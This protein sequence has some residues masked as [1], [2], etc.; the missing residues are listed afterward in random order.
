M[1]ISTSVFAA[2]TLALSSTVW[3]QD[4][5]TVGSN[6]PG[7]DI[8]EWVKGSETSIENGKV[9]VVEFWATWCGPCKQSIPHLTSLQKE[10]ADEGLTIIGISTDTETEKVAPFVRAQ[11]GKMDYTVAVDRRGGTARAWMEAAGKQGIPCAFIVDRQGKVAFIG[12]PHPQANEGF[13][14]ALK[15]VMSGRFDPALQKS[16]EPGMKAART[17][18]KENNWRMAL[19]HYDEV[20]AVDGRIF[21]PLAGEKFEMML[22]DMKDKAGAY[23]YATDT[24]IAKT[25]ANDAEALRMMADKIATDPKIDPAD[26]DLDV[27]LAAA[28]ASLKV[29]GPNNAQ[30]LATLAMVRFSRGEVAQAIDL[31]KQA[32]MQASSK[33]KADYRRTLNT[34]QEASQRTSMITPKK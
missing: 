9:Y 6:A 11:A 27:A 29:A 8:E 28:E 5:L 1:R 18:R 26:R 21:A 15:Q 12:N 3:A 20:I 7:L 13:E 30:S 25:F 4:K 10:F 33:H 19:K 34:Y 14:T 24:L 31:Q 32:W 17:A 2:L 22:V 23:K 16:A